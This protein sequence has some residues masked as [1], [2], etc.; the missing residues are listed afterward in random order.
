MLV[1]SYSVCITRVMLA[2]QAVIRSKCFI[3]LSADRCYR[4]EQHCDNGWCLIT[5][6]QCSL[7]TSFCPSKAVFWCDGYYDCPDQSDET[8]C[9]TSSV[10]TTTPTARTSKILCCI[11]FSTITLHFWTARVVQST[12]CQLFALSLQAKNSI[13]SSTNPSV[14]RLLI[15]LTGLN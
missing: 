13:T 2:F 10:I 4:N 8:Q 12:S 14:R 6:S 15:P 5:R 1:D 11:L 3:L 9:N 7:S